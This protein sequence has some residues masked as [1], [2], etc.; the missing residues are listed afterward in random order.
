MLSS[1]QAAEMIEAA[2]GR[3]QGLGIAGSVTVLDAG[4]NVKASVRMDGAVLGSYDGAQRKAWTAVTSGMSTAEWFEIVSADV[5]FAA[6][7]G[8]GTEGT[9]FLPG[10]APIMGADGIEGAIGFSGGQPDQ[11]AQ[12]MEA[13]L[14]AGVS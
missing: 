5:T 12:V 13:A 11:D 1:A 4:G 3:A 8:H 14:A 6:I 9:L 2:I 7:V 10:G